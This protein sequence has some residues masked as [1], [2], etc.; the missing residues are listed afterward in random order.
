MKMGEIADIKS[1]VERLR[2]DEQAELLAWLIE[3]DHE[4]WDQQIA[5]DLTAGKLDKFIEEA[6]ADRTAGRARPL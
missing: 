1:R 3:R 4:R 6:V 2:P 5:G